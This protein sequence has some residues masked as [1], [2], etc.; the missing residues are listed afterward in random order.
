VTNLLHNR[1]KL[2]APFAGGSISHERNL[3]KREEQRAAD[4]PG[5][6]AHNIAPGNLQEYVYG[7]SRVIA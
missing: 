6:G 4:V 1:S 7:T 5:P 3:F 2:Y